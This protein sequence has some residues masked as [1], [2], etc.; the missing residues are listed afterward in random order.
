MTADVKIEIT[1]TIYEYTLKIYT[2]TNMHIKN[3]GAIP[4]EHIYKTYKNR[5]G[6]GKTY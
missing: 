1:I 5:K 6:I 2:H 4:Y 3:S